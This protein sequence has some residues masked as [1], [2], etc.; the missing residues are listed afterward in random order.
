MSSAKANQTD[1]SISRRA[2]LGY[3]AA[4]GLA[5][6]ALDSSRARANAMQ[7]AGGS[8]VQVLWETP[9]TLSPLFS[10]AGAEQQVERL[11][12]GA[13]VKIN[14]NLEAVPDLAETIDVSPDARIYT[15]TLKE[16]ITFN[17]GQPLTSRDVAFTFERAA[18]ARTGSYWQGRLRP[19]EG[20]EAYANQQAE[21]I[22][23]LETPDERTVRMTLTEPNAVWLLELANFSGFGILP[24][25]ILGDVPP[26]ALAE[27]AFSLA[28]TVGA[29]AYQFVRYEP[30]QY[31]ELARNPHYGHGPTPQLDRIF[32]RILTPDVAIV[33]MERGNLDLIYDLPTAEVDRLKENPQVEI[34][35]KPGA[36]T[37]RL[38]T[39]LTRPVLQDKRVR[40]AIAY[41]ID[42]ESIVA[43]IL[44]GHAELINHPFT[45]AWMNPVEGI[46]TY[47][48]DP[49][50][51]R[52]LLQGRTG[53]VA[54]E[55]TGCLRQATRI[56]MPMHR[57][58]SSSVRT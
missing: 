34:I 56:W 18:D 51:A 2:F 31:L 33:E 3:G 24:A 8:Q 29:G 27:H 32:L 46:N 22:S 13:L 49:D 57:S 35:E 20:V 1:R 26:D 28:P 30:D 6:H 42:R 52:Q 50:R 12:F 40:Q 48:Y 58:S 47:P 41:A 23:G 16:G 37:A 53:T 55:S 43:G 44:Q 21:T 54:N 19:I 36:P 17:D 11:I 9:R 39:N 10:T 4:A 38:Q 25:H 5:A 7:D 15:F 45:T 14:D